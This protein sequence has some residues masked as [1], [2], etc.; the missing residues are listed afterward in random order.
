MQQNTSSREGVLSQNWNGTLNMTLLSPYT[1]SLTTHLS[2]AAG[3]FSRE[4]SWYLPGWVEG[5]VYTV[6]WDGGTATE[7]TWQSTVTQVLGT[8]PLG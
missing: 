2:Q 6:P 1:L 5:Y 8:K 7:R 4:A 3:G